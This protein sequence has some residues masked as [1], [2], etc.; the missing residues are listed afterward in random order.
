VFSRFWL[1]HL[2][3]QGTSPGLGTLGQ[4]AANYLSCQYVS[5]PKT[6]GHQFALVAELGGRQAMAKEYRFQAAA[7]WTTGGRGIVEAESPAP[8]IPFAAPPQFQGESGIWTPEHFFLAA[9]ASCFIITFR[10]IA[11]LSR[12]EP[13]ALEL[14]AEGVLGK[15][16]GGFQFTQ[17]ILRPVITIER[18]ED[19]ERAVRLLEKAERSCLVSRSSKSQ[20]VMEPEVHVTTAALAG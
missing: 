20:V 13:V 14:S 2:T 7:R 17:V 19:R 8:A 15:A 6:L 10:T 5:D 18:E 12:F 16:E 4:I 11:E 3:H 1:V 9:I